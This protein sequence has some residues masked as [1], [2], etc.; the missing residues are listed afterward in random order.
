M[1]AVLQRAAQKRHS[2]ECRNQHPK[3]FFPTAVAI[4]RPQNP[5]HPAKRAQ[6][7]TM[8]DPRHELRIRREGK[9]AAAGPQHADGPSP[10]EKQH[11]SRRQHDL[12]HDAQMPGRPES[13]PSV[14]LHGPVIIERHGVGILR[15]ATVSE[16]TPADPAFVFI[17]GF[18]VVPVDQIIVHRVR[19]KVVFDVDLFV[20]AAPWPHHL[21]HDVQRC[22]IPAADPPWR[23]PCENH[24]NADEHSQSGALV[25]GHGY[26]R[27]GAISGFDFHFDQPRLCRIGSSFK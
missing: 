5:W 6:R 1:G 24:G 23:E 11:A 10:Q 7:P 20:G 9:G 12:A 25:P 26:F 8:I 18:R 16:R 13:E 22:E 14:E 21:V 3:G 2:D 15:G 19:D 17:T 4:D 27:R